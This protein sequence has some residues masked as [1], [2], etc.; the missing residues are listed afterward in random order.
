MYIKNGDR[1]QVTA[2]REKGKTGSVIKI[3]RK[4]NR[5]V[6]ADV[7]LVKRHKRPSP[8]DPDGGIV[9]KEASLHASN[10]LLFSEKLGRGVR[11]SYRFVG[12]GGEYHTTRKAALESFAA[13]PTRIEKVRYC[14]KTGEVF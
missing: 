5:V 9:E 12:S 7:N 13:P 11:V 10:V 6:V 14:V 3:D 2:G 8:V 1:V 4:S